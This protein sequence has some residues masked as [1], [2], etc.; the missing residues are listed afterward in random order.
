MA[1]NS[2]TTAS[3]MSTD[4]SKSSTMAGSGTI[5]SSTTVMTAAG[6]SKYAARR[7]GG[8]TGIGMVNVAPSLS[9]HQLLETHE[10]SEN[11][12]HGAKQVRGNRVTQIGGLVERAGQGDVFDDGHAV[13]ARDGAD[14]RGQVIL[15]FRDHDRRRHFTAP[16]LERDRKVG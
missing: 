16:I 8:F 4:R 10:V 7:A 12:S 1:V 13:F 11:L 9:E 15:A 6:A 14:A 3:P 2:R 5:I